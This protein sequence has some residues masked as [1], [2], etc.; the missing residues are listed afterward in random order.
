MV[1]IIIAG[2]LIA[3]TSL[4]ISA[5]QLGGSVKADRSGI[6]ANVGGGINFN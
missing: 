4:S 5:C 1:R 3:F 2:I 6:G